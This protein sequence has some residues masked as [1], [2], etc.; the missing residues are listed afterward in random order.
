[1]SLVPQKHFWNM[2]RYKMR[3]AT[4]ED[5]LHADRTT[6]ENDPLEGVASFTRTLWYAVRETKERAWVERSGALPGTVEWKKWLDEAVGEAQKAEEAGEEGERQKHRKWKAVERKNAIMKN[7]ADKPAQRVAV[8][9]IQGR[10]T[11]GQGHSR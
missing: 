8:D 9:G 6:D 5:A 3:D 4:P 1:M 10:E 7:A 2:G 11:L